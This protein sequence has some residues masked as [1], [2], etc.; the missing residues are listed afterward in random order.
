VASVLT[1][2]DAISPS[3][4]LLTSKRLDESD[5]I[6]LICRR[7]DRYAIA[8]F[9]VTADFHSRPAK[10]G[11][12]AFTEQWVRFSEQTTVVDLNPAERWGLPEPERNALFDEAT[13][14]DGFRQIAAPSPHHTI[15]LAARRLVRGQRMSDTRKAH[16]AERLQEDPDAWE[17]AAQHAAAWCCTRAVAALRRLWENGVAPSRRELL[18][19][20]LELTRSLRE[21]GTRRVVSLARARLAHLR[22]P[23]IVALSGLDG[24]GKSTQVHQLDAALRTLG[25]ESRIVWKPMGHSPMMRFV[26]RSA[27]RL[28]GTKPGPAATTTDDAPARRWD[29]NPKTKALRERSRVAT[30]LW[31]AFVGLSAAGYYRREQLRH[32]GAV[33]VFDR[34]LLD[35]RGQ[36]RFFYGARSRLRLALGL[37]DLVCPRADRAYLLDVPAEVA[38]GRKPL[39]YDLAELSQQA[40]LY[41]QEADRLGASCLDATLPSDVLTE[42][43]IA[44]LWTRL[45]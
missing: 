21:D 7:A 3:R 13:T 17:K 32:R 33:L 23:T 39:Q 38:H 14:L 26:R 36:L 35:T 1:E 25:I 22:S 8:S 34:H 10:L 30:Q 31:A 9:L 43:I 4:V 40:E 28:L 5:D 18:L 41:R 19:A 15:L 11:G 42:T 20:R 45:G 44:D 27:K 6:D 37:V 29:P 12:R 2:I 16:L 24:S